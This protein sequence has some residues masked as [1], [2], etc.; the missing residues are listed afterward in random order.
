MRVVLDQVRTDVFARIPINTQIADQ[1][2]WLIA[3]GQVKPGDHLPAIRRLA[4]HLGINMHTVRS[5]YHMLEA[6]GLVMSHP[7]RGTVVRMFDRERHAHTIAGVPTFTIGVLIPG[8]NPFYDPLLSAIENSARDAP[9]LFFIGNTQNRADEVNRYLDQF[10]AKRVDGVIVVSFGLHDEANS[11]PMDQAYPSHPPLVFADIPGA[12]A[13]SV[14]FDSAHGGYLAGSHLLDHG[15]V[16]LGL[17]TCPLDWPN[18]AEVQRGFSTALRERGHRLR[19]EQIVQCSAFT[20][21][22]GRMAAIALL[23]QPKPPS[24]IFAAGDMLAV[25]ALQAIK[26]RGLRVPEDLALVGYDDSCMSGFTDPP[27]TTVRL[28]AREMGQVAM[29]MLRARLAGDPVDPEIVTLPV[30]LVVRRSCGCGMI[31]GQE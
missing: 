25:G 27:I 13:P 22:E 18:I 24:A 2:S 30:E 17:V 7:G 3:S 14:L 29:E 31:Q 19:P 16:H 12:P 21:K 1:I 4:D 8:Y 11:A 10:L 26:E 20:L 6:D 15:H 23:D 28:P 5:A 9:L